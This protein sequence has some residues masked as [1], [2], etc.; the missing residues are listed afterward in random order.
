MNSELKRTPLYAE[1]QKLGAKF[2]SFCGWELP[3]RY[4][5]VIEEHRA[6][7]SRAGIFDICHMG[8]IFV[9]GGEAEAYADFI[10]LHLAAGAGISGI[11]LQGHF[12]GEA[13]PFHVARALNR[14]AELKK[15]IKITEFDCGSSNEATRI[16]CLETVYRA[17]FA[18]P[19]VEGILMWGFWANAHWRPQSALLHADF[20]ETALGKA[21]TKLVFNDWWTRA[22]GRT[23]VVGRYECDAFYGAHNV[24]IRAPGCK[25]V[26]TNAILSRKEGAAILTIQ[27]KPGQDEAPA[28]ED[29]E[30][31]PATDDDIDRPV[32]R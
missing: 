13:D 1:H 7:R 3:V 30:P 20:S 14:L 25:S 16:R 21:Y 26:Y 18:N 23:D 19:A 8:E 6:V 9:S 22:E 15:P 32:G 31:D 4:G 28:S 5:G 17:A 12:D 10:Q 2:V 24:V 27:L 11:G 29:D